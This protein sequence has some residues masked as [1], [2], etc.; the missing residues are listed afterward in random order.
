MEMAACV[1]LVLSIFT[2][3]FN[4]TYWSMLGT[5]LLLMALGVV[6]VVPVVSEVWLSELAFKVAIC[7]S[8]RPFAGTF[9]SCGRLLPL[10][11]FHSSSQLSSKISFA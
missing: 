3:G 11:F 6:G 4:F 1:F 5:A 8:P 9:L 2:G 10:Q 7:T